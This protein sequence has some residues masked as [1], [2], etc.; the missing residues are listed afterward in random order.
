MIDV[1]CLITPRETREDF[2]FRIRI[3]RR[4]GIVEDQDARVECDGAREGRPLLLS[5]G[6]RDAA[7]ADRRGVAFGKSAT[8]LSSRATAAA[9]CTARSRSSGGSEAPTGAERHVVAE[10]VGE[11]ERLLRHEADRA[12]KN[13]KRDLAHVD[14]VD[15][16]GARAR[17]VQPRKQTDEGGLARAR[18][19]HDRDR[20]TGLDDR[21]DA[22]EDAPA[23]VGKRDVAEFD[24]AGN[25]RCVPGLKSRLQIVTAAARRPAEVVV[26]NRSRRSA[27]Q[28][29]TGVTSGCS[30]ITCS[31]RFHDARPRWIMFVT[32]PNAIIGQRASRDRH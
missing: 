8:S 21:G 1:R 3:H 14:A 12:A 5:A 7:L 19:T 11:Q 16:H 17:V 27:C 6:Q 18:G 20:L 4:Q 25:R 10:G 31:M 15:E 22:V 24:P 30:S 26:V 2:L 32:Q 23:V 13:R 29:G 28:V 9:S